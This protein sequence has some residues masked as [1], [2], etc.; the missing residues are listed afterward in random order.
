MQVGLA[1]KEDVVATQ[2]GSLEEDAFRP[3]AV[4]PVEAMQIA[5]LVLQVS[6][7]SDAERHHHVGRFVPLHASGRL[8][9]VQCQGGGDADDGDEKGGQQTGID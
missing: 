2:A 8:D 1:E 6:V 5:L 4:D 9:H 7:V 3:A